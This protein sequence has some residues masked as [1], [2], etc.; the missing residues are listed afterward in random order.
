[1]HLTGFLLHHFR[2]NVKLAR[3]CLCLSCQW[4]GSLMSRERKERRKISLDS[5][6]VRLAEGFGAIFP[7]FLLQLS[8]GSECQRS[9]S[10]AL[11]QSLLWHTNSLLCTEMHFI[12]KKKKDTRE[13]NVHPPVSQ[14]AQMPPLTDTQVKFPA[15]GSFPGMGWDRGSGVCVLPWPAQGRGTAASQGA[16]SCFTLVQAANSLF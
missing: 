15:V 9:G 7:S 4:S 11:L 5:G 8:P 14:P 13:R 2:I 16:V 3:C 6:R 10:T 12:H 1:M